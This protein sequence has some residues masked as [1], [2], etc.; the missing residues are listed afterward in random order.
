MVDIDAVN[1]ALVGLGPLQGGAKR[2]QPPEEIAAAVIKARENGASY[3]LI[4]ETLQGAG[5]SASFGAVRKWL[6]ARGL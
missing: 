4:A 3:N 6:Q 5:V 2:W 1:A